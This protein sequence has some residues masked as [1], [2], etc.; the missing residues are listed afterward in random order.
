LHSRLN[1]DWSDV[2][3]R[4]QRE[5][6]ELHVFVNVRQSSVEGVRVGSP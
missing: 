3:C 2:C 4:H 1:D 6:A 5:F